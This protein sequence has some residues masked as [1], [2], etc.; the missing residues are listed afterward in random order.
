MLGES[1]SLSFGDFNLG[2]Y[3]FGSDDPCD[4]DETVKTINNLIKFNSAITSLG[5][6]GGKYDYE[7]TSKD[8][9]KLWKNLGTIASESKPLKAFE[10]LFKGV[11]LG[12]QFDYAINGN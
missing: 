3:I 12:Y 7:L 8:R 10:Y 6:L 1:K 11:S 4:H 9:S 5:E 2:D